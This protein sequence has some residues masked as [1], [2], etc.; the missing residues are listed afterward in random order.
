MAYVDARTV[1]SGD[2]NGNPAPQI[3][4]SIPNITGV[5]RQP[6][7]VPRGAA[8]ARMVGHPVEQAFAIFRERRRRVRARA[9]L[10]A[11]DD[12]MLE[13]IGITGPRPNSSARNRSGGN[14]ERTVIAL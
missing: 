10:A 1:L 6:L 2:D 8:I 11:L 9:E 13:D 14:E 4:L 12:R 5:G 3:K 7:R